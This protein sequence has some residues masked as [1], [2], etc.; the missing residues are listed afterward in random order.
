VS[1]DLGPGAYDE[2]QIP[3]C[4]HGGDQGIFQSMPRGTTCAAGSLNA[5]E[6]FIINVAG[7]QNFTGDIADVFS[8]IAALGDGGC[9]L[10][11]QL[12][13]VLRALGADGAGGAPPD[14]AG[15]LRPD[16]LLAVVLVTNEDDCSAPLNSMLFDPAS[17][18]VSDPLGPLDSYRCNEFG[19]LC[20]GQRPP[21]TM[22]AD[23][24]GTC[25]SAE[26]GTLLKVADVASRLK[27]LKVDPTRVLVSAIAGPTAPYVVNLVPPSV[28]SDPNMW[29]EVGHSCTSADGIYG[30]PSIRLAELVQAFGTKGTFQPICAD[31][32]K[33][34][35]DTIAQTVGSGVDV[36]CLDSK[37]FDTNTVT[38]GLQPDCA[39]VDHVTNG[40]GIRVDTPISSCAETGNAAPCWTIAADQRCGSGLLVTFKPAAGVPPADL[41]TTATCQVC[42]AGDARP[43]CAD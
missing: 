16:A 24:T 3:H 37:L 10:E 36:P 38:A 12:G 4:R 35:L 41:T 42:A 27:G 28:R 9:G 17:T 31:S 43:G 34:A 25:H 32:L 1:S 33:P 7:Q 14:N 29:P 5:G 21:R 18:L 19:H 30:D 23:L 8:C 15:F 11:H 40:V 20:G 22:A 26:D 13:S 39:F 6:H 2:A